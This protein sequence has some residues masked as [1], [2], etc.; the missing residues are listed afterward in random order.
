MKII[1]ISG[2]SR[3]GKD[4]FANILTDL[5]VKDGKKVRTESFAATL[6]EE[7]DPILKYNFNLNVYSQNS[8]QK[9]VFRD[10]MVA[11]A[12]IRRFQTNGQ[13]FVDKLVERINKYRYED[14][15]DYILIPD[16]RFGEY[17]VPEMG[18]GDEIG[19]IKENDGIVVHISLFS[20]NLNENRWPEKLQVS[21]VFVEPANYAEKFND[22]IVKDNADFKVD[23][24][25]INNS[26]YNVLKDKL[27]GYV[28]EVYEKIK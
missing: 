3:C 11:W 9:A 6:R 1:G 22:P 12:K 2:V 25:K 15:Y 17:F 18:S 21:D 8:A 16:L 28:N 23:W 19:F 7:L 24:P 20:R 10:L 5:M 4:T 26:D 13:Y 14:N 27:I